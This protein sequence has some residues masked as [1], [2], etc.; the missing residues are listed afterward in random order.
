M[1]PVHIPPSSKLFSVSPA[2]HHMISECLRAPAGSGVYVQQAIFDIHQEI[3]FERFNR[4]LR[5]L[6]QHH[7][8]FRIG[9]TRGGPNK[10]ELYIRPLQELN[11]ETNDWSHHPRN[12]ADEFLNTFIQADRR[13]GFLPFTFPLFR[14]ALLKMADN[15]NTC[16]FSFFSAIVDEKQIL[17]ILKDLFEIYGSDCR[18]RPPKR[19][20]FPRRK[21]H[22][23]SS[24]L[25]MDFWKDRFNDLRRPMTF[26]FNLDKPKI[27][28]DRRNQQALPLTTQIETT[29]IPRDVSRRLNTFC[30]TNEIEPDFLLMGAFAVILSH[31]SGE[32]KIFFCLQ[33]PETQPL[34][35]SGPGNHTNML[36]E[37]FFVNPEQLLSRFLYDIRTRWLETQTL[38]A[39]S[40]GDIR[41]SIRGKGGTNLFDIAFS[42]QPQ[43]PMSALG[44]DTGSIFCKK[45]SILNRIPFS[46]FLTICG[47][48]ELSISFHYDR[49]RFD[50]NSIIE[51]LGHLT[52]F[53]DATSKEGDRPLSDIPILSVKEKKEIQQQLNP[54][55]IPHRPNS[56]LHHLFEIQAAA[57]PNSNALSTISGK[58]NIRP[59][60]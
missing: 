20:N 31:Y 60:E 53:L 37:S 47:T 9:F 1:N 40:I 12:V 38:E 2:Q 41:S 39:P 8:E 18:P 48:D 27:Q 24:M 54:T 28:Q 19:H 17:P 56:C 34:L 13:L 42:F 46:L 51:M 25:T 14:V 15:Y 33:H 23:T 3:N 57:N 44:S 22:E 16:I 50:K 4:A 55:P 11:I 30:N 26:P 5:Y 45:I 49:R 7:E 6:T 43:C 36:P 10:F 32:D 21:A 29:V 35:N 52:T 58:K 59:V